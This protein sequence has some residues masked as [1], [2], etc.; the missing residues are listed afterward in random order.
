M[1]L[2]DLMTQGVDPEQAAL[3]RLAA[4]L[5]LYEA[6]DPADQDA[7]L[8]RAQTYC[9]NHWGSYAAGMEQ[10]AR[11]VE[12]AAADAVTGSL[13]ALRWRDEGDD[14]GQIIRFRRSRRRA[15][16]LAGAAR[17]A[18]L[19]RYGSEAAARAPTP[20]EQ[21]FIGA[22]T[23]LAAED[24]FDAFAPL[25]GWALPWHA[26][27]EALAAAVSAVRP[28]P[29]TVTGARAEA[30]A[31]EERL[32]ELAALGGGPGEAVLPTACAARRRIVEELWRRLL[33]AETAADL[34]A[35]LEYWAERG[36]D[37]G[38]GYGVALDDLRRL[39]ARAALAPP[40][41][42]GEG[43]RAAAH[44][45]KAAHPEWSLAMIGKELGISRQAVH[46]HLKK[47]AT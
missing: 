4:I 30:A 10:F 26:V 9:R 15:S 43:T 34:L 17:A 21:D 6:D 45:L 12:A 18:V 33:P 1:D 13:D 14:P 46:K 42:A 20:L 31:W 28:L 41:G 36:G 38:G 44:R 5:A 29:T 37:D 22:T 7:A 3:D 35:R 24:A 27:P 40:A 23:H 2:I 19:A 16:D 25:A 8:A 11:R 47:S 32:G 39:V